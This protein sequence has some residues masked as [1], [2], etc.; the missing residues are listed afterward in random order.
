VCA[1][2]GSKRLKDK[3]T[4]L[5]GSETLTARACRVL[6]QSG[7]EEVYCVSNIEDEKLKLP[8]YITKLDRHE[9]LSQDDTPLQETVI[10]AVVDHKL[11][12]RFNYIAVLMANCPFIS[13]PVV[14]AGITKLKNSNMNIIRSYSNNGEEN[15]LILAEMHYYLGHTIDVYSGSIHTYGFEIHDIADYAKAV[16]ILVP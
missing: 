5:I 4:R 8:P 9:E 15:G 16:G 11:D 10:E 2:D 14:K 7:I 12:D 1:R 3:N 13:S 6:Y